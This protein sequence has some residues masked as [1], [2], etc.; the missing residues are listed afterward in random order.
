[1]STVV[2]VAKNGQVVIGADSMSKLGYTNERAGYVVNHSK[3]ISFNK[4]FIACVGHPSWPLVLSHCLSNMESPPALHS[5]GE[6]F[7]TSLQLH[8]ILSERYFI[9]TEEENMNEFESSQLDCLIANQSGIYGLYSLRS[10]KQY[11]KYYAFGSG[12]RIALGAMHAIYDGEMKSLDI[13]KAGLL[14]ACDFDE[15]TGGPIEV[16]VVGEEEMKA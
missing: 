5:V 6:I 10:V 3:I 4:S 2:V 15:D 13:A 11:T 1:V 7:D 14:A 9:R 16:R 12:A 8:A